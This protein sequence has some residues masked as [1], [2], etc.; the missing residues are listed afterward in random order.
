MGVTGRRIGSVDEICCRHVGTGH[1]SAIT[2]V[3][4]NLGTRKRERSGVTL[5]VAGLF[6]RQVGA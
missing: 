1:T 4:S 5:A 3:A 2:A 6:G